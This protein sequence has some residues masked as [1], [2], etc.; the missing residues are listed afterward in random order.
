MAAAVGIEG[1]TMFQ[2][3]LFKRAPLHGSMNPRHGACPVLALP[4]RPL[5]PVAA[6]LHFD[7]EF[8]HQARCLVRVGESLLKGVALG[9]HA[10]DTYFRNRIPD[11]LGNKLEAV[12]K[13]GDD[14][15]FSHRPAFL[16]ALSFPMRMAAGSGLI[17][18][19]VTPTVKP[20]TAKLFK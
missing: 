18:N 8:R 7:P 11:F 12:A 1:A 20:S 19:A 9:I 10:P 16:K 5:R 6:G 17:Q 14:K 15:R 3:M 4:A 2:E 13:T